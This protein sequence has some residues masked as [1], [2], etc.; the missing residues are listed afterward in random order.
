[1]Q[2]E[3]SSSS[4]ASG[5]AGL[6]VEMPLSHTALRLSCQQQHNLALNHVVSMKR[7]LTLLRVRNRHLHPRRS[8]A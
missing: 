6:F 8:P 7:R 3:K 5:V 2:K 1:M 4:G